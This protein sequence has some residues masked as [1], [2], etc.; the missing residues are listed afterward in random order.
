LDVHF[1][2]VTK[3]VAAL[4]ATRTGRVKVIVTSL[5]HFARNVTIAMMTLN[6]E[7]FL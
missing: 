2:T 4:R 7:L 1:L 5:E 6:A 3:D